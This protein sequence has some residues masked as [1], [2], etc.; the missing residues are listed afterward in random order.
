MKIQLYFVG[1]M[2]NSPEKDIFDKYLIRFR[3]LGHTTKLS[4]TKVYECDESKVYSDKQLVKFRQ[5]FSRKGV[6]SV[7]LDETG[8]NISSSNFAQFLQKSRDNGLSEIIFFVGGAEGV[9]F[10]FRGE[11]NRLISFGKMVWPHMIAR[12]M[13]MEQLYR[14]SSIIVGSPYHK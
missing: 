10:K 13:L 5:L 7:L 4:P 8:H 11:F 9:P 6:V 1:K 2:K 3:K 12:I 14:A